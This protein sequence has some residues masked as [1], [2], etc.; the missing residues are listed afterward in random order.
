MAAAPALL[1]LRRLWQ[2]I[3]SAENDAVSQVTTDG[4]PQLLDGLVGHIGC[5]PQH[6]GAPKLVEFL[7]RKVED[8]RTLACAAASK[9]TLFVPSDADVVPYF[10]GAPCRSSRASA[11]LRPGC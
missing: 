11:E 10:R 3:G 9:E 1:H 4:V 2:R 7:T 8:R 6:I 5:Q